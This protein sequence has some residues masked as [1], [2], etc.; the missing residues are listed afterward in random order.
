VPYATS[1]ETPHE[2]GPL[3]ALLKGIPDILWPENKNPFGSFSQDEGYYE[4]KAYWEQ[5]PQGQ[6]G[7]DG[8]LLCV[9]RIVMW[10]FSAAQVP[11]HLKASMEQDVIYL[12]DYS[13]LE[14]SVVT[15]VFLVL[16]VCVCVYMHTYIY[17]YIY[18]CMYVCIYIHIYIYIYIYIYT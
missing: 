3:K 14:E 7:V 8:E 18:L 9:W 10:L 13:E 2:A 17:K 6:F 4:N 5:F 15:I 1:R 11:E 16:Q 12:A